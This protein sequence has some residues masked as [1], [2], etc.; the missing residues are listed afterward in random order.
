M[1]FIKEISR[2][3]EK[4]G[5]FLMQTIIKIQTI[6]QVISQKRMPHIYYE[7]ECSSVR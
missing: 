1:L 6:I 5:F 3:S 2:M 7:S 4:I